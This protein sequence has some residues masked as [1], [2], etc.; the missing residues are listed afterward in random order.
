[1]L[2]NGLLQSE[3]KLPYSF[4][5]SDKVQCHSGLAVCQHRHGSMA[6]T[7]KTPTGHT[8]SNA[9]GYVCVCVCVCVC[10]QELVGELGGCLQQEKMSVESALK[11]VYQPQVRSDTHTDTHTDTHKT[12]T[13]IVFVHSTAGP[14]VWCVCVLVCVCV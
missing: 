5:I 6:D 14:H 3:E 1:M 11:V 8:G 13:M 10:A 12:G 2:L 4:Y 9:G 7:R